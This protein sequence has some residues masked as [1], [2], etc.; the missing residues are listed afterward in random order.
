LNLASSETKNEVLSDLGSQ[1][2]RRGRP[3]RPKK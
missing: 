2:G 3:P 1:R